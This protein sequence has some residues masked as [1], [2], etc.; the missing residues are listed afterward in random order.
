[1]AA[2]AKRGGGLRGRVPLGVLKSEGID[3]GEIRGVEN[4]ARPTYER[5]QG[6]G[7]RKTLRVVRHADHH[8]QANGPDKEPNCM[9]HAACRSFLALSLGYSS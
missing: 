6:K 3:W 5:L 1:M 9:W 8:G 4:P 2:A 7:K